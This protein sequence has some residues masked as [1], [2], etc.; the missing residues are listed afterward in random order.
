[1]TPA[2]AQREERHTK[3]LLL[4]GGAAAATIIVIALGVFFGTRGDATYGEANVGACNG[5]SELC[6]RPVNEVAFAAT[7]NSMSAA[8]QRGWLR[9]EHVRTI[10]EQ[11]RAGVRGFLIDTWYGEPG[12]DGVATDFYRGGISRGELVRDYGADTVAAIERFRGRLGFGKDGTPDRVYLCHVACEVGATDFTTALSWFRTFL[13]RNPGEVLVMVIQDQTKAQDVRD[14]FVRSNLLQ[15]VYTHPEDQPWPTLGELIDLDQRLIVMIES[16]KNQGIGW[17]LPAFG[18]M[19][20]T[21]YKFRSPS[22]MS[23]RPN[24]GGTDKPFFQ[25][26]N[27]IESSIPNPSDAEKVN[28]YRFL[29]ARA[30]RCEEARGKIP[31]VVA[32]DFSERG[33][34]FGV[35]NTLNGLPRD[36]RPPRTF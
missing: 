8:D 10:R 20:E 13:E 26:N 32:V 3:R 23:C 17:M 12:R 34:L 27:W 33:D 19:E 1:M 35:V 7:H 24:R 25:M 22:E 6:G 11:L 30:Q 5:F 31:S 14:A 36:A 15:Y 18:V 4:G 9:A 28:A 2:A 29:L 16:G 21:P